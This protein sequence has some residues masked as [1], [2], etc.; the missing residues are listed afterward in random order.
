MSWNSMLGMH[1]IFV[2][3]VDISRR[4]LSQN[5]KDTLLMAVSIISPYSVKKYFSWPCKL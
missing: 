2:T 3:D 5:S 1:M 4:A